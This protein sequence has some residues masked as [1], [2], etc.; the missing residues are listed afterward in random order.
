MLY[1]L[2][3]YPISHLSLETL[4][5]KGWLKIQNYEFFTVMVWTKVGLRPS[6]A[7]TGLRRVYVCVQADN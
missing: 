2:M 1:N 5:H 6:A 7:D 3:C 4:F